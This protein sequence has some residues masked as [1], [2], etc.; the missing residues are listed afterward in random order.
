MTSTIFENNKDAKEIGNPTHK[1]KV[2]IPSHGTIERII[3]NTY[4]LRN[5][6]EKLL[7]DQL[8]DGNPSLYIAYFNGNCLE[9]DDNLV[10]HGVIEESKL[11]RLEYSSAYIPIRI[12]FPTG[13]KMKYIINDTYTPRLLTTELLD[14]QF[15][16]GDSSSYIVYFWSSFLDLDRNFFETGVKKESE[17][18]YFKY[19][20]EH[21]FVMI[22]LPS[23]DAVERIINDT[24]TLRDLLQHLSDTGFLDRDISSYDVDFNGDC[25]ELDDNLVKHGVDKEHGPLLFDYKD[26]FTSKRKRGD[27][28][29]DDDC[30]I[31]DDNDDDTYNM[32]SNIKYEEDVDEDDDDEDDYDE[33]EDDDDDSDSNLISVTV[34]YFDVVIPV[35]EATC[36]RHVLFMIG[37]LNDDITYHLMY[38]DRILNTAEPLIDQGVVDKS[39]LVI[40]YNNDDGKTVILKENTDIVNE[41]VHKKRRI[42]SL[43]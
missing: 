9:L 26:T 22:S 11:L 41:N 16:D 17:L 25:L 13:K 43:P 4:T 32:K 33:E 3:D 18:T 40:T 35:D 29:D 24:Y 19:G 2:S 38:E 5:F 14:A 21:T 23:G 31:S 42:E 27:D 20:T 15:L 39:T 37:H 10:K 12:S 36:V 6:I 28:D 1:I 7:D 34:D 30:V 8:L